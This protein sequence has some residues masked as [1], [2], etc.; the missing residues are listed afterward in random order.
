[1]S[2]FDF[3]VK[4]VQGEDIPLNQYKGNIL[5]IVNTATS[6]GFTPQYKE[7]EE[8]YLEYKADGFEILDFP[9]NQF[10]NQAKGSN[11]DLAEFCQLKYHTTFKTF[12]RIDV[13]GDNAD[14][15]YKYLKENSKGLITKAIKWN[16]TKFL[17]DREGTVIKRFS[18]FTSPSKIA[19]YIDALL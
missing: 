17:V 3:T 6:C 10:G 18:S 16:F 12:A 2:V 7:L 9:C 11:K 14:P 1:M 5:L 13:N 8:L 19:E 4:D 15:L